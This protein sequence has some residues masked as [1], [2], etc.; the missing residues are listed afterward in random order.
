MIVLKILLVDDDPVLLGA[1]EMA[2]MNDGHLPTL[3]SS[4]QSGI[5]IFQ[6]TFDGGIPFD[7]VI[8]DLAMPHVDGNMVATAIKKLSP[9]TPIILLTGWQVIPTGKRWL[10]G[11]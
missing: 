9:S 4:G 10:P 11:A 8:T 6:S 3:A 5:D 2:L 7:L 1:L